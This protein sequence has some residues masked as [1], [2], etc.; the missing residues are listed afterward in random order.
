MSVGKPAEIIG[1]TNF[2]DKKGL[3]AFCRESCYSRVITIVKRFSATQSYQKTSAS[4]F[5]YQKVF[6]VLSSTKLS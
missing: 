2:I 5:A 3:F 1:I 6:F 4:V